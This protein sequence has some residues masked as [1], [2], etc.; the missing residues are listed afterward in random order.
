MILIIE[1]KIDA[2]SVLQSVANDNAGANLL[3][4]GTTRRW[5]GDVET[6]KL[7][8]ECYTR[9]AEKEMEQLCE[10]ACERWQLQAISVVHRVGIVSV[11]EA[12]LAVA[13]SSAHRVAAFEAGS[14][15]IDE[16][17]K[18]VPI[19]KQEIDREGKTEWV[20]PGTDLPKNNSE[21]KA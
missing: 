3:F 19:W 15:L 17:K 9:M 11:G 14:W 20:H 1:T 10:Q 8:Y 21:A 2:D 7:N 13:I 5:T 18:V 12:S 6:T 16:I 4:L